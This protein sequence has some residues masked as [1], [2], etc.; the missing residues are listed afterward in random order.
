MSSPK[1]VLVIVNPVSGQRDQSEVLNKVKAFLEAASLDFTVRETEGEGDARRWA[2]ET[3]ADLVIVSGGDGTV[4]EAMS[5]VI[6]NDADVPLA[7]LPG[8]TANLLARALGIPVETEAALELA[9]GGSAVPFDVGYLPEKNL[10]FSLMAGAGWDARLIEDATREIKNRLGFLAYILT[11]IKNL[12][13][14]RRSVVRLELDGEVKTFRAHTVSLINVGEILDTNFKLGDA[15]TPHD[16]KLN[17][18]VTSPTRLWGIIKLVGRLILKRFESYRD[19]QYFSVERIHLEARPPLE[20]QIDGEA[21]G[22]TPFTAE[23]VP[24]AVRLIVPGEYALKS[25]LEDV[26]TGKIN[27][28]ATVS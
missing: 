23:I 21:I 20:V 8:G 11:G 16:G 27:K 15:I 1:K 28:G 25:G 26:K 13:T 7:Q 6:E 24:N 14:L 2:K 18:A 17:V 4:M 10:Y 19:L 22:T 5:G 3:D 9:L 12:F